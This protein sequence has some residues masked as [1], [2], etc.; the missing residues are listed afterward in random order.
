[1]TT[2]RVVAIEKASAFPTNDALMVAIWLCQNRT[3]GYSRFP[4]LAK[5]TRRAFSAEYKRKIIHPANA[6]KHGELGPFIRREKLYANQWSQWRLGLAGKGVAGLPKSAPALNR[7]CLP[8]KSTLL[9]WS[10]RSLDCANK[11]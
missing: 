9:N 8:I 5:R 7:R 4:S 1:M 2:R 11:S 6:C 10:E 3:G